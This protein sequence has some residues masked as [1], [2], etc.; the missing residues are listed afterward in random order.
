M[1]ANMLEL[2]I[3]MWITPVN[4][5]A[6]EEMPKVQLLGSMDKMGMVK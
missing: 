5:R 4:V 2:K 3:V 6:I 1:I